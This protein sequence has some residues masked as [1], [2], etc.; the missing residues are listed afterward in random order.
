MKTKILFFL[1][2]LL[3]LASWL[4]S[5]NQNNDLVVYGYKMITGIPAW[6]VSTSSIALAIFSMI[7]IYKKG[8]KVRGNNEYVLLFLM[9]IQT[10]AAVLM[11]W[12]YIFGGCHSIWWLWLLASIFTFCTMFVL[13]SLILRGED[14]YP[15]R[16]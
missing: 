10:T 11:G 9:V 1:L 16:R 7:F 6:V 8:E 5:F 12:R 3:V 13:L 15:T 2:L 14:H 4:V